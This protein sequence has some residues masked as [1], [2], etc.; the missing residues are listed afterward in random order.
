VYTWLGDSA[1]AFAAQEQAL[2]LCPTTLVRERAAMLFHRAACMIRDGDIS[3]GLK[4]AELG[5]RLA[6]PASK[7]GHQ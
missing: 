5:A 3:G 7:G 2:R 1:R 4:F 6:L